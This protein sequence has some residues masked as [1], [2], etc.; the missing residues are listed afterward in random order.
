MTV[1]TEAQEIYLRSINESVARIDACGSFLGAYASSGSVSILEAAALQARKALEA[2]A[3]AA[4]A[5]NE[6]R[7]Q[8]F[9]A[10]ATQPAD[11]R[12]DYNARAILRH[13]AKINPD[14]YPTP[15]LPATQQ[16]PGHWHFDLKP[17]GYLTKA[18]FEAFYDRLGKFLHADNPW[19]HDKGFM[20]L[21]ADLPSAMTQLRELLVLHKTI[22][23]VPAFSG[24]WVIEVPTDGRIPHIIT[25]EAT[26][27][28][29]VV[30]GGC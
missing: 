21:A 14:F 28:F 11:Y 9:R 23:R 24:V 10:Q 2:V 19:G 16:A 12:K 27:E 20:N 4:I 18:R 17:D 6:K 3:Y 5:P 7:Y 22:V 26:G 8:A 30:A 29:T 15:L 13:L 25:A 1:A